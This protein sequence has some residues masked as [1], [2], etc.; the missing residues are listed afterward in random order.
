MK[1]LPSLFF[2]I[3]TTLAWPSRSATHFVKRAGDF[4]ADYS[5]VEGHHETPKIPHFL[6]GSENLNWMGPIT[7]VDARRKMEQAEARLW[8]LH[9]QRGEDWKNPGFDRYTDLKAGGNEASRPRLQDKHGRSSTTSQK[10]TLRTLRPY[11]SKAM[12]SRQK[13]RIMSIPTFEVQGIL[14]AENSTR[15]CTIVSRPLARAFS[16]FFLGER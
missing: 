2:L 13:R 7:N 5:R 1:A 3:P 6:H 9:D 4:L 10:S 11:I 15:I 12:S 16:L 8:P 14:G